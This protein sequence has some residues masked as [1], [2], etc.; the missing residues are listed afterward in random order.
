VK[1]EI[2]EG[3]MLSAL[4]FTKG[5]KKKEPTFLATLKLGKEAKEVQAP[6]VVQKVLNEFKDIMR[7]ELPKRLPP[8]RKSIMPSS[9]TGGKASPIRP[10]QHGTFG[11]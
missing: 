10:L 1:R 2:D 8:K 3:K 4:Q 7:A 5:I 9:W 11:T 6:N